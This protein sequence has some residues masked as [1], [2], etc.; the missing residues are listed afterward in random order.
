MVALLSMAKLLSSLVAIRCPRWWPTKVLASCLLAGG[1][2]G[3]PVAVAG[4]GDDVGVV[5]ESVEQ[6]DGGGLV[7]EEAAPVVER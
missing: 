6:A 1:A 7:G 2:V 4:G 5:A 3:E